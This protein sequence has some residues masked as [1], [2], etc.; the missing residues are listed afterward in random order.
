M[1]NSHIGNR[2]KR[3][4]N[5]REPN[6][7]YYL[8]FTDTKETERNYFEGLRDSLPLDV[9]NNLSIKNSRQIDGCFIYVLITFTTVSESMPIRVLRL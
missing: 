5:F 2:K 6:L 7:G 3:N 1:S 9:R 8:I 4:S